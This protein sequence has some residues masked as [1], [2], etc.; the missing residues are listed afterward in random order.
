MI[1]GIEFVDLII[2]KK[3]FYGRC[4]KLPFNFTIKRG[5]EELESDS[6]VIYCRN[7]LRQ[8]RGIT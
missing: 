5:N 4:Y 6:G 7:E 3:F 2:G 8:C 1:C